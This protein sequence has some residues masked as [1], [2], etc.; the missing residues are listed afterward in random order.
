MSV[1]LL[2]KLTTLGKELG[3][4]GLELREWVSAQ[5]KIEEKKSAESLEREERRLQRDEQ[6][7]EM[8]AKTQEDLRVR[9]EAKANQEAERQE[10]LKREELALERAKLDHE[11]T[12]KR[13]EL[14]QQKELKLAEL[15]LAEKKL[16]NSSAEAANDSDSD[17]SQASQASASSRR[18]SRRKSGPKL[19]HFDENKDNIDS[20]LHRFERYATLQNWPEDDW[21]TYLSALLKGRALEVYNR[22]TE[23]E[24]RSYPR[25]KA[26]LLR[27]YQLTVEGFRRQFYA[28]RRERDE[29]ASQFV[30]RIEGYLDRWIQL[31]EIEQSFKGLRDLIVREQ[32]LSVCEEHLTI[33]LKERDPKELSEVVRLA[34]TYLGARL[35]RDSKEKKNKQSTILKPI[36]SERAAERVDETTTTSNVRSDDKSR[37]TCYLCHQTGHMRKQCPFNRQ[38]TKGSTST[39]KVAVCQEIPSADKR[40][41]SHDLLA[42][43][44]L[45]LRCGCQLPYVGCLSESASTGP[46]DRHLPT[47]T[48]KVNGHV[49]SVLRDTGCTTAV[50]RDGL[51]TEEQRTGQH[52][53]YRVMD[54]SIGKA[55][56]AIV[57]VESPVFTGKVECLCLKSPTCDLVIGNIPGA[58]SGPAPEI[59][60]V[61]TWAQSKDKDKMRKPLIVP[62][63]KDLQVST[64]DLQR[65]QRE[66]VDLQKYFELA[67]TQES[68]KSGKMA[69]VQYQVSIGILYRMFQVPGKPEIK[70]VMVPKELRQAVLGLAHDSVMSGHEGVHK[71][72]DR[73]MSNFWWPGIRDDVT[74]YCRSC[75]VCQRTIPRGRVSKAPLQKMPIIGVPFQRVGIDLVGPITPASS[76]GKRF[77]L[78][79]ID[80]ATRY[81][82]AVALSGIS[83]EEVAE[84]L[85]S[86]L[87][88]TSPSPRDGLLSRMPSSA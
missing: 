51:V 69:T 28:A 74:R 1:Q 4:A 48:G 14:E 20:Y 44:M 67:N 36:V 68:I 15:K 52:K 65:L 56:V 45:Q 58:S 17:G 50:V 81:P 62:V 41:C 47:M 32:F 49:V 33:Y 73:I 23:T 37:R 27:K 85:C 18:G 64:A 72:T 22:L 53:C 76:S 21:A 16:D 13:L 54:G 43:G 79:V 87:L 10:K 40:T 78:T 63:L 30:C 39:E 29:T 19:P 46:A 84:A 66:S 38:G 61:T 3:Y 2:E 77:I 83:T 42:S 75:D 24:A 6:K 60:A 57:D 71:T 35:Q 86:C 12:L 7:K 70:Q 31:A 34:D 8:A 26:A 11:E 9:A 5:V 55:E 88:Y 82:E 25:L 80:Y 59:V